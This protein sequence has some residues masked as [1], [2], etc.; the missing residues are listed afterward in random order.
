MAFV[1]CD[2]GWDD[3][4]LMGDMGWPKAQSFQD[5][6]LADAAAAAAG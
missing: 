2:G 4:L 3:G 5:M 6:V 1:W